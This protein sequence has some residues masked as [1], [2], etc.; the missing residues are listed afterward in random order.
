M[1]NTGD[2]TPRLDTNSDFMV[3]VLS[4]SMHLEAK[5]GR[6][7]CCPFVPGRLSDDVLP[8]V[9]A[10]GQPAGTLLPELVQWLP[11]SALGESVGN[12]GQEAVRKAT[13]ILTALIDA[14]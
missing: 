7:I 9:V 4:S 13:A 6:I 14:R 3:A 8:L 12:V 5:T 10:V 1:I 2:V 11:A